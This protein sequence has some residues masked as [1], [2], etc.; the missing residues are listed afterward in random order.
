MRIDMVDENVKDVA[1]SQ[2]EYLK[3]DFTMTL[4]L[5]YGPLGRLIYNHASSAG[6][7]GRRRSE[8]R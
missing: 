1:S 4:G 5:S 6:L 3:G 2:W 8:D 7:K